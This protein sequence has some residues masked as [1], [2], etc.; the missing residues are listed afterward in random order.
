MAATTCSVIAVVHGIIVFKRDEEK[1]PMGY[2]PIDWRKRLSYDQSKLQDFSDCARRF[3]LRYLMEQE[4]P[5]PIAEPLNDAEQADILG[6]RFHKLV[7]RHLLGLSIE[8]EKIDPALAGWWDAFTSHP[9]V[10]LPTGARRPEVSTSALIHGQRFVATFDLLAYDT[11]GE[12]VIVDWKTTKR[13]SARSWLDS[14]LQT[15]I[16]PLLLVESSQRLIG[17]KLKPEQV[18]LIYWFAN[19]PTDVEVFQYSTLRLEQD[20]AT[21]A[22]LLDRLMS[23]EGAIWPLTPNV[24]RCQWCQYRSLCERGREAGAVDE[25]NN[26]EFVPLEEIEITA[27]DDYVL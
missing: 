3:Q 27:A 15:I 7:E 12:A 1:L 13:R 24:Q 17:Y 18:K 14:R 22:H 2:E 9:I 8:R 10:S 25:I 23:T 4:W 16:Y 21:L 6:K 19:A 26:E 5:A 20:R 11:G